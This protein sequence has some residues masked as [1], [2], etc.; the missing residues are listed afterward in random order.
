MRGSNTGELILDNVRVPAANVLGGENNGAAVLFS[1]LD[2]ERL[3]L[4]G[5]PVGIMAAALDV[6][7]PYVRERHQFGQYVV[8][9]FSGDYSTWRL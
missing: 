8:A 2:L 9:P 6:A 7:V 3:V 5:L 1:G 4:S